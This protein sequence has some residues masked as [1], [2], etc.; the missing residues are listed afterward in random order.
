MSGLT[1]KK[2][3]VKRK[4]KTFQRSVMVR[5]QDPVTKPKRY[6]A[7]SVWI[8]RHSRQVA[9]QFALGVGQGAATYV[10][11]KA[12]AQKHRA[13]GAVTGYA[14]YKGSER[15]GIAIWDRTSHGAKWK[16]AENDLEGLAPHTRVAMTRVIHAAG[17]A[18][19][20]VGAVTA[21]GA[22]AIAKAGI[23]AAQSHNA[24][25]AQQGAYRDAP[26]NSRNWH[27]R[28]DLSEALRKRSAERER[29]DSRM[30]QTPSTQRG[31]GRSIPYLKLGSGR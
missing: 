23:R 27:S 19:T 25:N 14:A 12:G 10:G 28:E 29:W 20:V 24:W 15:L 16:R 9:N 7:P 18:G 17:H 3:T 6:L 22:H 30:R 11:Y 31:V 4:G 13:V 21:W 26:I 2:I 1:R 8:K 5:V